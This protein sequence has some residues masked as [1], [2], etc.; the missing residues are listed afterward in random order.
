MARFSWLFCPNPTGSEPMTVMG[1]LLDSDPSI[2]WQVMRDLTDEPAE[3]V[4][5]EPS[6]VAV[7]GWGARLLALQGADGQWEGGPISR[8]DLHDVHPAAAGLGAGPGK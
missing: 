8:V 5:A 1:W 4:A 2:R 7:K 3:A 6:R